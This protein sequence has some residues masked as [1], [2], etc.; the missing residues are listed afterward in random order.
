MSAT[1]PQTISNE[2]N[3][4]L[5]SIWLAM[6]LLLVVFMVVIGGITR[7]TESGLSIVEWKPISGII[8]PMDD[9]AFQKE[10]DDYKTSP[11]FK[12]TFP[13]MSLVD[14]KHIYW[15]EYV[16]RLLG[17]IAGIVFLLPLLTFAA[18]KILRGK[19]LAKLVCI[20]AL[21]G[22]QGLIGWYM[23]KSGLENDPH[24][25]QYRL[26]LHLGCG[27]MLFGLILW[28]LFTYTYP[29][30]NENGFKLPKPPLSLKI[31]SCFIVLLIFMQII[32]GAFVAGLHAGLTYNTFPLMDGQWIPEGVWPPQNGIRSLFEDVATVQF[33]HRLMAYTLLVTLPFF[34]LAGND[35]PHISHLLPIL[36]SVFIIQLLLGIL[37]L[38]FVVPTPLASLHQANALLFFGIAVTTMHRLFIPLETI[39]YDTDGKSALA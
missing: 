25:S 22:A 5:V 38:L 17:R 37:T 21:G 19:N 4:R 6:C 7:L 24:V 15:L 33:V 9:I 1:Q 31:F 30:P 29:K 36:F 11:Q 3:R 23:V 13:D 34:W 28:Q 20:F 2:R 26:A 35:N 32:M 16:H 14:F 27:F 12:K 10:F 18:L 8:P 39:A